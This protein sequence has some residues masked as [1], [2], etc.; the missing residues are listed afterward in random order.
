MAQTVQ[1]KID[2]AEVMP[3]AHSHIRTALAL[4]KFRRAPYV[5]SD[6][7]RAAS[8]MSGSGSGFREWMQATLGDWHLN[9]AHNPPPPN[10]SAAA[11][12]ITA[13]EL[14]AYSVEFGLM[15]LRE[16]LARLDGLQQQ[17]VLA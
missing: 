15:Q 3:L 5:A 12:S 8:L 17:L 11:V 2:R 1:T 6:L 14:H 10:R 4:R 7:E 16:E 9:D 13:D